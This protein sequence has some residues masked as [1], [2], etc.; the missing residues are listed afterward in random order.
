[1]AVFYSNGKY[2]QSIDAVTLG[3]T[4]LLYGMNSDAH[5]R[6]YLAAGDKIVVLQIQ[7][8]QQQ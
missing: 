4:T 1:M 7:A 5:N 6:I 3:F 8:A 2:I